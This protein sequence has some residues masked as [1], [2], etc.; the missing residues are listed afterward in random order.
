MPEGVI[1]AVLIHEGPTDALLA[2]HLERLC[3]EAGAGQASC[4][5]PD[6]G[7]LRQPP[8]RT[9]Q[10]QCV[11][12]MHM[13]PNTNLLFVHRDADTAGPQ[14]RRD[15]I[16]LAIRGIDSPPPY[17]PVVPVQS[18]EAWLLVDETAIRLAVG[19]TTSR[20]PVSLPR[21]AMIEATARPKE[22]LE[23]SIANLQ[24]TRSRRHRQDFMTVRRRLLERLDVDGP[25]R[26]LPAFAQLVA[27]IGNRV[28]AH[29]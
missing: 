7:M 28:H 17:V 14:A 29:S 3:V 26:Q 23:A 4:R 19:A 21:L 16:A 27:D 6:F 12:A 25:V 20:P 22:V 5:V 2:P 11:A 1:R 10:A 9:V 8:G 18:T 15:E 24:T 13:F